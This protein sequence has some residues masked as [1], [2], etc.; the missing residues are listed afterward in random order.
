MLLLSPTL[1]QSG[2][3]FTKV[4]TT[5]RALGRPIPTVRTRDNALKLELANG[6]TLQFGAVTARFLTADGFVKV[7]EQ[8]LA[9]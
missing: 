2:E 6:A 9:I 4:A 1:R 7:L 3:L 5:Y 8:R